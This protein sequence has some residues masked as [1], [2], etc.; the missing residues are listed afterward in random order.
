MVFE[1]AARSLAGPCVS[2]TSIASGILFGS[3]GFVLFVLRTSAGASENEPTDSNRFL[4]R[5]GLRRRSA[6]WSIL[7]ASEEPTTAKSEAAPPVAV[8]DHAK[9]LVATLQSVM[10]LCE[11]LSQFGG[12]LLAIY[13]CDCVSLSCRNYIEWRVA[14]CGEYHHFQPRI[15]GNEIGTS[16]PR[17]RWLHRLGAARNH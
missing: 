11:A 13:V 9:P 10:T 5:M 3:V 6:E 14:K 17:W 15:G 8:A 1:Y 16:I 12:I 2:F 7:P 4:V